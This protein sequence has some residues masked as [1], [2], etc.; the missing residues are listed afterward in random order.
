MTEMEAFFS[1]T[2]ILLGILA[3][4]QY[5]CRCQIQERLDSLRADIN[6]L[7]RAIWA[8]KKAGNLKQIKAE[9]EQVQKIYENYLKLFLIVRT[10]E[11]YRI[12]INIMRKDQARIVQRCL[13][14][15]EPV[16]ALRGQDV[17]AVPA[18]EKYFDTCVRNGCSQ[19]FLDELNEIIEEFKLHQKTEPTKLPN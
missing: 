8:S 5:G 15:D 17:C 13:N 2:I 9:D 3:L 11:N 6:L 16:F 1:I 7:T 18:L 10:I 14:D 19:E 12:N 4:Y